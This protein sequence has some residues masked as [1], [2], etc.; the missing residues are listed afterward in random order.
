MG[1]LLFFCD[2]TRLMHRAIRGTH[3]VPLFD[4]DSLEYWCRHRVKSK[5]RRRLSPLIS[6]QVSI[7]MPRGKSHSLR[8]TIRNRKVIGS[9]PMGGS[10]TLNNLLR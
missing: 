4:K 7:S 5:S 9:S 3:R 6:S 2:P 8:E 1:R 10:I